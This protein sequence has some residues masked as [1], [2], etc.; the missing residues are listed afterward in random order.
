MKIGSD[1]R[2]RIRRHYQEAVAE[3]G[4]RHGTQSIAEAVS[5]TPMTGAGLN[6]AWSRLVLEQVPLEVRRL[7]GIALLDYGKLTHRDK[8]LLRWYPTTKYGKLTKAL[9]DLSNN[10]PITWRPRHRL[11]PEGIDLPVSCKPIPKPDD[12]LELDFYRLLRRYPPPA[13]RIMHPTKEQSLY[14]AEQLDGVAAR[15]SEWTKR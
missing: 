7:A 9:A 10:Q 12:L 5:L 11:P 6:Q 4:D 15:W 1:D 14:S 13:L 8:R 2:M 3:Q